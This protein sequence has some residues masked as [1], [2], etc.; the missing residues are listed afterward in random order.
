VKSILH[1]D[2]DGQH[3]EF[4]QGSLMYQE[5]RVFQSVT[6]MT[7]AQWQAKLTDG[8]VE[9]F[10][11]LWWL[12]RQRAGER[13]AF[14]DM[15]FNVQELLTGITERDEH[16]NGIERAADGDVV[17]LIAPDGTM[18]VPEPPDPTPSETTST[19]AP[20]TSNGL[21]PSSTASAP[22]SSTS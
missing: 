21:Q 9:G 13:L 8:D 2:M 11:A 16:G 1:I 7:V 18:I 3:W 5:S 6:H 12:V 19:G 14:D 15:E 17:A 10:A 22:G 20:P 4:E